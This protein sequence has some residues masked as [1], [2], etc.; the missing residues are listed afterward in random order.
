MPTMF[1]WSPLQQYDQTMLHVP[2]W[3]LVES[4]HVHLRDCQQTHTHTHTHTGHH[5]H[6]ECDNYSKLLR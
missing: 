4:E 5:K 1:S 2:H 6:N 3:D